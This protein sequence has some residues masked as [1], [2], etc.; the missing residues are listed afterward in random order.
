MYKDKSK[1]NKLRL[2]LE[3]IIIMIDKMMK[4]TDL[5]KIPVLV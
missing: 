4:I 1:K 3:K 2:A 5:V